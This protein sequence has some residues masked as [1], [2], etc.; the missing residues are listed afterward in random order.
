MLE[1]NPQRELFKDDIR[2]RQLF[3]PSLSDHLIEGGGL[4]KPLEGAESDIKWI[5]TQ[6]L[7]HALRL[8]CTPNCL[9]I[10][11]F[12]ALLRTGKVAG[13]VLGIRCIKLSLGI[14]TVTPSN[15]S[16]L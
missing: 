15:L 11:G 9:R 13:F 10:Y 14:V 7:S 12:P 6:S 1:I 16:T 3:L 4:A 2:A 5:H 8:K